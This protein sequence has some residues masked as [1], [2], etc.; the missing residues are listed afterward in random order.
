[1]WGLVAGIV[2]YFPFAWYGHRYLDEHGMPPGFSRKLLVFLIASVL[3]TAVGFGVSRLSSSPQHA[4]AQAQLQQKTKQ[5]LS[6]SLHCLNDPAQ[7][8][9]QQNSAAAMQLLHEIIDTEFGGKQ[10]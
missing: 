9:C 7:P 3:S 10:S 8:Q 1:M 5:L 4:A 2:S 6:S